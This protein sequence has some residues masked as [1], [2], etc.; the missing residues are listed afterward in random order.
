M[1][2]EFLNLLTS[3]L[4]GLENYNF[5]LKTYLLNEWIRFKPTTISYVHIHK[6][7]RI[8]INT[9]PPILA[10]PVIHMIKYTKKRKERLK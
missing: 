9:K 6:G 3:E 2:E 1:S 8:H 4:P 7:K 10:H 5:D